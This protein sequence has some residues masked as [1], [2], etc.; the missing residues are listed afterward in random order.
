MVDVVTV[1]RLR[2]LPIRFQVGGGVKRCD[3]SISKKDLLGAFTQIHLGRLF[4]KGRFRKAEPSGS[5]FRG[6]GPS[7]SAASCDLLYDLDPPVET[8]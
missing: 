8:C 5:R 6:N 3:F 2:L 4:K 7:V 1:G